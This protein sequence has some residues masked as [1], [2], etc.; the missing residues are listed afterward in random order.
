MKTFTVTATKFQ[1]H[2][3]PRNPFLCKID[4]FG[5]GTTIR[6]TLEVEA[7]D[8]MHVRVL[9]AEGQREGWANV[10]GFTIE[11]IEIKEAA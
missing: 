11:K 5:K 9:W 4:N 1:L 3:P 10:A 7:E 2:D 8:E 6:H